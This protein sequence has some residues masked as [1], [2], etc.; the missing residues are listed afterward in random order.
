MSDAG[1]SQEVRKAVK[2]FDTKTEDLEAPAT[3][4]AFAHNLGTADVVVG[5][6]DRLGRPLKKVEVTVQD[7]NTIV[8][9]NDYDWTHG[10]KVVVIG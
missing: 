7:A 5:I 6:Y 9:K 1:L 10:D 8:V 2:T 4:F 3:V